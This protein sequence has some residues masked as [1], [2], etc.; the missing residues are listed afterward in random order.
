MPR[1]LRHFRQRY[2]VMNQFGRYLLYAVGEVLLVMLGI[3]LA[4]QVDNWNEERKERKEELEML[5]AL[6]T[7]F[8]TTRL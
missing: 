5:K 2:L 7:D 3:L 6:E 8:T 4:L 1:F